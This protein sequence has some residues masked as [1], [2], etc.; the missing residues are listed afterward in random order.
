M[1]VIKIIHKCGEGQTRCFL[2]S[3]S[4]DKWCYVFVCNIWN[5]LIGHYREREPANI[6]SLASDRQTQLKRD[7]LGATWYRWPSAKNMMSPKMKSQGIDWHTVN[8]RYP[9]KFSY[10]MVHFR[11]NRISIIGDHLI[12]GHQ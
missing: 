3:I 9:D 8:V 6:S 7:V 5:V 10:Q 12:S 1:G 4:F 2:L 11:L